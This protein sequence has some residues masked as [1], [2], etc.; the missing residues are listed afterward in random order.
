VLAAGLAA[1]AYRV[2]PPISGHVAIARRRKPVG[3]LRVLF[4]RDV[5]G[6]MATTFLA[7]AAGFVILPSVSAYLLNNL[8]YPRARLGL[9]YLVGGSV[10]FFAMRL[11]G[12]L[13]DRYGAA[14][15]GSVGG[16]LV[17]IVTYAGFI[18]P[19]L[20][21]VMLFV[22]LMLAMAFRNV[23][24]NTLMSRVPS[25]EERARFSSM[26]SAVQHLAASLAAF[27]GARILSELPNGALEGI[28]SVAALSI[29]ITLGLVPLFWIVEGQVKQRMQG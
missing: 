7:T 1:F 16:V 18:H 29:A 8:G 24:F 27:A 6:A 25:A 9:L 10:S 28:P 13:V 23:A 11:V 19:I 17:A 20:T 15:I 2:L 5:G 26:Q 22:G 4:R 21:P 12:R 3:D 14:R